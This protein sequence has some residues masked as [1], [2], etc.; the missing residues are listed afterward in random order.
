MART[1]KKTGTSHV[2]SK[3]PTGGGGVAAKVSKENQLRR[4]VMACLLWEDNAYISGESLASKI[5]KLVHK[6][7]ASIV[8]AMAIEARKEQKLRHVPL[9]LVR[10]L[11]RH[12]GA[13]GSLVSDTI[14]QVVCRPDELSE[15]LSLYWK[16]NDGKKS[17]PRQ[18]KLGLARALAKF[19]EYQL[20]KWEKPG[21]EVSI[22]DVLFLCHAK[23]ANGKEELYGKL[24]NKELVHPDTWEKSISACTTEA[25]KK[26]QW[27]R[28]IDEGKLGAMA[29][30][31]NLRNMEQA[32]VGK[33][34]VSDA[35]SRASTAA[36]LPIDFMRAAKAAPGY[37]RELESLMLRCAGACTRLPGSTILVV[38]VSG[39]M[40]SRLSRKTEFTRF[41]V[42]IAMAILASEVCDS[43]AIYATAGL[44]RTGEHLTEFVK[45]Y[46]G[47][48]L[49]DHIE[50][51]HMRKLGGGGIFTRQCLEWIEERQEKPDR[52]IVF[53]DSQDCDRT[54]A[55]PK[56]FGERNYIVDVSCERRGVNFPGIWDAEIRGWSDRFLSYIAEIEKQ[57]SENLQAI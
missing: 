57:E 24:A 5:K 53:S 2:Y 27:E 17:L 46:R 51:D 54:K 3:K 7:D 20:A 14:E 40:T 37:M 18:L 21:K 55:Q 22:R 33:R 16:T 19:S 35:I 28:L 1:N 25:E 42:A 9:L 50:K 41:D 48:A 43:L 45:P 26:A 30:L 47:F 6:V 13:C 31:K 32:G 15:L 49:A 8:A 39:S 11:L 52:L 38:D 36:L 23:P 29:L 10:E 44:D 12:E 56:P 34:N 4:C